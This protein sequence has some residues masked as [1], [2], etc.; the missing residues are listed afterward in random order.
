MKKNIS[1]VLFTYGNVKGVKGW[2][3]CTV[4]S[5]LL[6]GV[7]HTRRVLRTHLLEW[8]EQLSGSVPLPS[9]GPWGE[10]LNLCLSCLTGKMGMG[11]AV[12]IR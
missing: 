5:L 7:L 9:C 10:L 11:R 1:K 3:V 2:G 4:C 12:R 8:S 6:P